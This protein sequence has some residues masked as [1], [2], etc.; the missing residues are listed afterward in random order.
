MITNL[1]KMATQAAKKW[2]EYEDD[3]KN[4]EPRTEVSK[5]V[6]P[7]E[8]VENG[9]PKTVN[10]TIMVTKRIFPVR[11]AVKERKNIVKFG[12]VKDI[13]KGEHKVGDFAI[14][15]VIEIETPD[16]QEKNEIDLVKK[17]MK[18]NTDTIRQRKQEQELNQLKDEN[19][20]E[21]NRKE[22]VAAKREGKFRFVPQNHEELSIKIANISFYEFDGEGK[23][24][25]LRGKEMLF[26]LN[27]REYFFKEGFGVC[28]MF[29]WLCCPY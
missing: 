4:Y 18:I 2:E 7:K 1:G 11:R 20:E 16:S 15:E 27:W 22:E 10:Q 23:E 12:D 21:E 19:V 9:V 28:I 3:E 24:A 25:P 17:I 13:P 14:G 8:V 6:Q 29:L 26:V 5:I